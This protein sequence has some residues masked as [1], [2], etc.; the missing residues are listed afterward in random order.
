MIEGKQGVDAGHNELI[1]H[2]LNSEMEWLLSLDSDAVVH[3]R[4][5]L[6]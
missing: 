1:E 5:W 6:D 4:R 3:P 2:F